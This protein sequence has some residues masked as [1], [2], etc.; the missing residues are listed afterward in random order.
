MREEKTTV[1]LA[2]I[3]KPLSAQVVVEVT[4]PSKTKSGIILNEEAMKELRAKQSPAVKV[5]A[6]GPDVK[7][8]KIDD[9]VLLNSDA[10]FTNLPLI[11]TSIEEG[12]KHIQLH[13]V[14]IL[15]IVDT[16]YQAVLEN[17]SKESTL[18]N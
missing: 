1:K 17:R 3:Y 15:G 2:D 7:S 8:V 11:Y 16:T 5:V 18:V 9:Y 4:M 10:R 6:I 13:E 14:D 12:I